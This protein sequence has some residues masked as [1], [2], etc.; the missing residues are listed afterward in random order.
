MFRTSVILLQVSLYLLTEANSFNNSIIFVSSYLI[1]VLL[2][3]LRPREY[4]MIN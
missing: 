4:E 2:D 1:R 3:N